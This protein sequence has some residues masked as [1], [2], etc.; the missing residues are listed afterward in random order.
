MT[1]ISPARAPKNFMTRDKRFY[2]T[3]FRLM[4]MVILQNVVAYSVNMADNLML[5]SYSQA[6]LSGAAA[7]NQ[8]QFMVQQITMAIGDAVVVIG[9]Q[10]W[11]QKELSPIRRLTGIAL[12]FGFVLGGGIFAWTSLDPRGL[13]SLFTDEEAYLAEGMA[14]LRLVR[15]TYPLYVTTTILM[16]ALRTVETVA[17]AL[18][19]SVVS[20]ILDVAINETLIFGRFG[21]PELGVTGAAV[22]TLAARIM[23]L[24]I[25][26]LYLLFRDKKLRLF[27]ENP[28]SFTRDLFSRYCRILAPSVVSNFVW[29]IATP[30]QTGI[31]GHLSSDAIAANSVSVTMFQYLKIIVIGEAS[32][33]SVVIGTAVGANRD[34]DEKVKEYARTLQILYLM[35]GFT[36]GI[37]LYFLRVPYLALY[38]L[39]PEAMTM[40]D[41]ILVLLCVVFVGMAYQMPTCVGIIKGGGDVKYMM[42]LNMIGTWGIVMP[43]T[44]LGAYVWKLPIVWI[45]ALLNSDQIFKCVPVAIHACRYRWIRHLTK[46]NPQS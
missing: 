8:I 21:A 7:A 35:F 38:D 24:V 22:G 13:L 44:F 46:E 18:R 20:L 28:F 25:V 39:T 3:L 14:Y 40:A 34:N 29:S 11:G 4:T 27:S 31:L 12:L 43:L 37:A 36:L 10:Y 2:Q 45:V 17:I 6:A 33:S 41:Q 5:G 30:I 26:V 1:D 9:S 42:F 19:I 32:A 16:A 15:F 23:E